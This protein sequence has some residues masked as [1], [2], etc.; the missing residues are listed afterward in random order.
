LSCNCRSR[1][2]FSFP[3]GPPHHIRR[4]MLFFAALS[5]IFQLYRDPSQEIRAPS[6]PLVICDRLTLGYRCMTRL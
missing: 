4:D 2:G 1:Y 5:Q 3:G 6:R